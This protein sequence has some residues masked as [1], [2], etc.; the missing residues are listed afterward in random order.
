MIKTHEKKYKK[1]ALRAQKGVLD[2]LHDSRQHGNIRKW[3]AKTPVWLNDILN[4]GEPYFCVCV[5][6]FTQ[7]MRSPS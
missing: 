3:A 2:E 4:T 7:I 1:H 6:I 5:T